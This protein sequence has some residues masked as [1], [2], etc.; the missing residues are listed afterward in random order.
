MGWKAGAAFS[1][2]DGSSDMTA[3]SADHKACG[4]AAYGTWLGEGGH[5]VDLI[6]KVSRVETDYG[7]KGTSGR[8]EN[9]AFSLSAEYGRHFELAGGAFV[10]PQVEV[11]WGRIMGDDFLNSE[12][13]RIEQDDFDSLIGRMGVRAGFNFPKDKGLV[14]AR[15]SVLHEFKGESE[16]VASLGA[17]SVRMSD[18]IGGTWG[19]FGVGANFRLTPATYTYVDLERTTGGEV[20]EMWRWNVGVRHVF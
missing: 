10:E 8:F 1:Y 14:Y 4:L 15:A 20:S 16:A 3:G 2:T 17:K 18:D 7:I 13:V 12:G 9:N 11:T 5:F 6:A 19:E